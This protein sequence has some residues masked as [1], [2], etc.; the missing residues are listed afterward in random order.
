M[1]Q[2]RPVAE[3]NTLPRGKY[4]SRGCLIVD[5]WTVGSNCLFLVMNLE[6]RSRLDGLNH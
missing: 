4:N 3:T 6:V 5:E 2:R 1:Q